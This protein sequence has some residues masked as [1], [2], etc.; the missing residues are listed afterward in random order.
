MS[1]QKPLTILFHM[2]YHI[3]DLDRARILAVC[4]NA[5]IVHKDFSFS[6]DELDG[7]AVDVLVGEEPPKDLSRWPNLQFVQLLSSGCD[8]VRDNPI[9]QTDIPLCTSSGN[10]SVPIAQ[11]ITCT[12]LMQAHRM[13]EV[14]EFGRTRRWSNRHALMG[15]V[16]RGLTAGFV[17]YGSIGRESGRQLS[18]LGV[19]ILATKRDPARRE[20]NGFN[21][22][23]GTGDP[24]GEI[25]EQWFAP[26]QLNEMLP[27]CEF[28][29]VTAPATPATMGMISEGELRRLKKG[30]YV[31]VASRGGIVEEKALAQALQSG[32]LAGA[33]VDSFVEEPPPSTHPFFDA[34]N[35]ILSSHMS[36]M[37]E[38]Y[39]P[40]GI[41]LVCENLHRFVH[42]LPL[43]N[44]ASGE[45]GY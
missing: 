5:R 1:T 15:F 43:Y 4:P 10:H 9:W 44:R 16:I 13:M 12:L 26:N 33:V 27:L 30:A 23:P 36:G 28:L 20:D 29:I 24:K 7:R 42:H 22:W 6:L 38:P 35:V 25:P 19:R 17:G 39:W 31:I 2:P 21:P 40:Q 14:V 11:Y 45:L 3:T 8:H 18:A 34:P 37:Y 32:H 41:R